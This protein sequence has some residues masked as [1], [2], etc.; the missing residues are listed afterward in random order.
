MVVIKGKKVNGLYLLDEQTV[1]GEASIT[2]HSEDKAKIWHLRL[3]HMSEN[4]LNELQ[5]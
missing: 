5:K 4:S 3:G 2:N 1:V